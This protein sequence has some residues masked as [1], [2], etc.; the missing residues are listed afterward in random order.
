MLAVSSTSPTATQVESERELGPARNKQLHILLLFKDC[1]VC[2]DWILVA[3]PGVQSAPA[4]VVALQQETV[5]P[6]PQLV[7]CLACLHTADA[8]QHVLYYCKVLSHK[9]ALK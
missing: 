4:P 7:G 8:A 1:V 3:V 6:G 5:R 9:H 2:G